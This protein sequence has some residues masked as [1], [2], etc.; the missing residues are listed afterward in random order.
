MTQAPP[1]NPSETTPGDAS[2]VSAFPAAERLFRD[3]IESWLL[4]EHGRSGHH[5]FQVIDEVTRDA[6]STWELGSV[7]MNT[8][9]GRMEIVIDDSPLTWSP[10]SGF[11]GTNAEIF[12]ILKQPATTTYTGVVE[13][14]TDA[15]VYA[16]T[17]D[18]YIAADHLETASAY[19]AIT[20]TTPI[21][22]NWDSGINRS[23]TMSANRA[24]TNPTN[25]QPGTIRRIAVQGDGG[26]ARTLTFDTQFLGGVPTLAD[27]TSSKWYLL[28]VYCHT[29]SHFTLTSK[30]LKT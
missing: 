11:D 28:T 8:T 4:Y 20:D 21:V 6:D 19:A 2:V 22:F 23:W 30:V 3:T 16:A 13:K 15:E 5:M 29:A 26:T 10:V 18:K 12:D 1:F 7:V 17:A 24:L 14:A 25:G 27:I 9:S